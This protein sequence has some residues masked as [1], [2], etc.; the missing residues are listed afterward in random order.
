MTARDILVMVAGG[1]VVALAV[2]AWFWVGPM[3]AMALGFD[4]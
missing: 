4:P 2:V 3:M 1:P